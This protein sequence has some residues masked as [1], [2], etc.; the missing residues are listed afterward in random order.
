MFALRAMYMH[1]IT[2]WSASNDSLDDNFSFGIVV[3]PPQN[4]LISYTISLLTYATALS[5]SIGATH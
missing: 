2:S 3:I 4:A 1:I 5:L